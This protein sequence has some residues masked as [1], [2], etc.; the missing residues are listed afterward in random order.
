MQGSQLVTP[1]IVPAVQVLVQ[2]SASVQGDYAMGYH[3]RRNEFEPEYDND[4]EVRRLSLELTCAVLVDCLAGQWSM[5]FPMTPPTA[6]RTQCCLRAMAQQLLDVL[7][8]VQCMIADME[9]TCQDTEEDKQL[10][11]RILEVYNK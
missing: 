11:L 9:F 8:L 7:C 2:P 3:A 4:A 6:W 5:C 10:K 1:L